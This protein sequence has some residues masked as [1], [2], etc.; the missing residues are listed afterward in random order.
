MKINK[1]IPISI[2]I[3]SLLILNFSHF[4]FAVENSS[5]EKPKLIIGDDINYPPYSYLDENGIPA[6]FNIEI[7]KAVGEAMGY[8]VEIKLDEWS[9]IREALE[10]GKIDATSGMFYSIERKNS[11]S[12]STKHSITNG[13]I[14]TNKSLRL[15]SLKSL[16]GKTVVVQ[17]G[18]IIGESLRQLNLNINLIEVST[19]DEALK[20]IENRT[21]DYAALLKL[22]GLYGIKNHS[23]QNLKAQGLL[24]APNDYCMAVK[25]GNEDLILTLNG[26]LQIIKATGEFEQ[27][28]NKNLGV[29]EEQ[30]LIRILKT[31]RWIVYIIV[32]I[33]IALILISLT[34][35]KLVSRKTVQLKESNLILE[36]SNREIHEKNELLVASEE[37]LIAQLE[38]IET[39]KDFINFLAY[40][41]PLTTLPNRRKFIEKLESALSNGISGAVILL[42]LDNFKVINDTMGHVYGDQ[43]LK[44]VSDRLS[45]IV[46]EHVFVS[47]FG[48]DEF[49]ILLEH[50][51]DSEKINAFANKLNHIFDEKIIFD[52][53]EVQITFSTGISLFPSDS[54]EVNQLIMNADL[55]LYTIKNSGKNGYCFFDYSMIA[56]LLKKSNIEAIIRTAIET[57]G[58]KMVFQPQ[59]DLKTGEVHAYEALL[60]LKH[61]NL[62]PAEFIPIA[63]SD[64]SIIKIGRIVTQKVIEQ[65]GIWQ[66]QGYP[67]KP[68]SINFS[69]NQL[70]DHQYLTFISELLEL[71]AVDSKFIEIEITENIF[72]EKKEQTLIFLA[73]LRK[74]GFKISIDDFGT[75]YSSLSYL[76]FLPVDKIKLDRSLNI[77]FLEIENIKVM[78]SLIMLAQSLNLEVV[79]EGI[80][81]HE[82]FR[83]LRVGKCNYIQGYY[84]CK[85]LEIDEVESSFYNNY[86]EW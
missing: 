26:G 21:Y 52:E 43:V 30:P 71:N 22:P 33:L 5:I 65:L 72:L 20:L 11:Y 34:L 63:E 16:K 17:K 79:A 28:Y 42:D 62:S 54:T 25:K 29:Y 51:S 47:R 23:Y 80:E 58:F 84:F 83:R 46:E 73:E 74:K 68:V 49:L 44:G 6:G 75:G 14:F 76:T 67:I 35:N 48:G 18:D 61:H 50:E 12:F 78:D 15:D 70:Q 81:T 4:A 1:I 8:D 7:A 66:R 86:Y 27:I 56:L 77:K 9:K 40:H 45:E 57:D 38:E 53:N 55:A 31:Y 82:Q 41:D 19:V 13:D 37:E 59:V 10:N 60:R 32:S 69:A 64:G 85:P 24:L 2:L 39:Q 36:K 3:I